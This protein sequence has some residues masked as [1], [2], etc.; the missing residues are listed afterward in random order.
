VLGEK[1]ARIPR[2][3][4]NVGT[5]FDVAGISRAKSGDENLTSP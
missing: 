2:K 5:P 3:M 4:K 1:N